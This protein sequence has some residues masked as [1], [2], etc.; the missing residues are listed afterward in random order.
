VTGRA[1]LITGLTF[2]G[3][4]HLYFV[5]PTKARGYCTAV[6][7][8]YGGSGCVT[9]RTELDP[10]LTGDQS[11]PIVFHGS[12]SN[13]AAARLV[14]TYQDRSKNQIPFVWVSAPI[15][16]GFFLYP[17]PTAHRRP[18]DR[19]MLLTVYGKTGKPLARQTL[20]TTVAHL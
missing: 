19:P 14:V 5:A 2:N 16:A 20:R 8:P 7:G 15:S 6:S 11:G 1:R 18:G 9:Y 13:A 4:D 10:G 12:F 17:V 3:R